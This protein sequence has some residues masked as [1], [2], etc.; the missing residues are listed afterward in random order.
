MVLSQWRCLDV[1]KLIFMTKGSVVAKW[2]IPLIGQCNDKN[3]ISFT[4]LWCVV[5]TVV[6]EGG[7][8]AAGRALDEPKSN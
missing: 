1:N 2:L 4:I 5:C 8:A 3:P 6:E 7:F